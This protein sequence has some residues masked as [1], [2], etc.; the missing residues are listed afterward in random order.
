MKA[1][2]FVKFAF[3]SRQTKAGQLFLAVKTATGD[4]HNFIAEALAHGATGVLCERVD[5][6]PPAPDATIILVPDV[7]QALRSYAHYILQQYRPTVIGVA[8]SNGKTTT[9]EAIAVILEQQRRVFKN[10]GSYNGRYG[11]P[12]ALGEIEP[13]Y[14]TAVLEMACDSFGEIETLTQIIQPQIGVVTTISQNHFATL[15]SLENIAAETAHLL[16]ALP[17]HG[18][19][20]LNDD[21]PRVAA[22]AA[23]TQAR[24]LTFGC[25]PQADVWASKIHVMNEGFTFTLNYKNQTYPAQ[26]TLIG[27]H[28]I[29]S[30]LAAITTGVALD[31]PLE[32]VLAVIQTMPR[33]PGRMNLLSGRRGSLI[34]DDTFNANPAST[35]AALETLAALTGGPKIAILGSLPDLG[36]V[37]ESTHA[38]LGRQAANQIQVLVTKG[39]TA[40]T[41]ASSA[42]AAGLS[43]QSIHVTF[44]AEDAAAAI[45]PLLSS[46]AVILVKGGADMRLECVIQKL[47]ANP[48]QDTKQLVRQEPGWQKTRPYQPARPTWVAVD[49][50]AIATNIK[51]L[52]KLA[53]PAQV[54]A[55]LK[56]DAY[57]HGM[58]KIARTVLN[59]GA[60]W[61]GVAT[62]GEALTL[63][64]AGIDAPILVLSYLPA[65]QA[66]DAVRYNITATIFT[67]ELAKA[68]SQAALDLNRTAYVHVKVDTGLG[69]LGLLPEAVL[70]FLQTIKTLPNLHIAA[71]YTHF[72]T[73]DEADLSYAQEQLRR[74]QTL[75]DQLD[76]QALRPPLI[77]AANTAALLNL[78]EAHFD[79]VR[80]GIG[81]YGLSPS[82]AT[83][84]SDGFRSAL[85]FKSTIGQVKQLPPDSP[86]GYGSTYRTQGAETIAIIPVGYADGFRRAPQT[87]GDVLVKGQRAPL[88][89]RVSMDQAAINI[90]HIPNV[91]QGDEVVLIGQQGTETITVETVAAQLG[92]INYEVI[93][94]LL[95]RIPRMS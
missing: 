45:E 32:K 4:G 59:N 26:S 16:T 57:G 12:I 93:S 7:Q 51:Q 64:Q 90:T 27:Q 58:I 47:L 38:D 37:E 41:I 77:H 18:V 40:A 66:R 46:E 33:L 2:D 31:I 79:L 22:M 15:G 25:T 53:A 56:A 23:K 84:L 71:M 88:V 76:Q 49:L 85:T 55:I 30:L 86:I 82:A 54:M 83:Q 43:K 52:T 75:L 61:V 21:D 94:A 80:P 5:T 20:I 10:F 3:D 1:T 95:A 63:R 50:A 13:V 11:L 81:L 24:V 28:Q 74:F 87:W 35:L 29:Y 68:F 8:G 48:Q 60:A 42:Q 92:T 72:A 70:G 78:P 62:L 89:G 67:V 65:W 91:R 14:D 9:K 39:E 69:R 34:I 73:A 17:S 44:T 36:D 19:A 6:I